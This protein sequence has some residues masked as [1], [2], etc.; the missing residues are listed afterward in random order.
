M[1]TVFDKLHDAAQYERG[2][3]LTYSDV[4]LLMVLAG[5]E[6]ATAARQYEHWEELFEGYERTKTSDG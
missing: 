1:E 5:D 4:W 3:E 6:I 2:V